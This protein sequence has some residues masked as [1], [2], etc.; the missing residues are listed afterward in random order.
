MQ[1]IPSLVLLDENDEVIT[2]DGRFVISK[3][4]EG[5]VSTLKDLY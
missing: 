4:H 2:K 5:K 1:G 3:D